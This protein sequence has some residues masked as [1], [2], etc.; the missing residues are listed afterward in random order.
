MTTSENNPSENAGASSGPIGGE[1]YRVPKFL[2]S[3][4]SGSKIRIKRSYSRRSMPL[5]VRDVFRGLATRIQGTNGEKTQVCLVAGSLHGEGATYIAL[6]LA[7][8]LSNM[9][10]KPVLFAD[11]NSRSSI[12]GS[13][14]PERATELM[15]YL[16]GSGDQ[17]DTDG[18]VYQSDVDN[19][20]FLTFGG[21]GAGQMSEWFGAERFKTLLD[22]LR[23]KYAFIVIDGAPLNPYPD[24]L[25]LSRHA[26]GVALI[27]QAHK[28]RYEVA[29]KAKQALEDMRANILGVVVNQKK[30]IIPKCIYKRL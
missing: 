18:I 14:D 10:S 4:D 9:S 12:F 19:L 17:I 7:S 22:R 25:Q 8:T 24:S 27:I 13:S 15:R 11:F 20:Y 23:E 1:T 5:D 28:T 26:D 16:S 2:V 6:N 29:N 30:H 21:K 3:G